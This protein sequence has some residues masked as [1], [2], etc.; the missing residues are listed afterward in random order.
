M[1]QGGRYDNN[2]AN[3]VITLPIVF[4]DSSYVAFGMNANE[5]EP[6]AGRIGVSVFTATS[7]TIRAINSS[8]DGSSGKRNW[9]AMGYKA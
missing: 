3:V 2:S 1:V 4:S 9:L 6:E 8:N 7:F 5:D